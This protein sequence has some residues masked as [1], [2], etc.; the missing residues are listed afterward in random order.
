MHARSGTW[1]T[2]GWELGAVSNPFGTP[3]TLAVSERKVHA[4]PPRNSLLYKESLHQPY[5]LLAALAPSF[6]P[7]WLFDLRHGCFKISPDARGLAGQVLPAG[8]YEDH[9]AG[10]A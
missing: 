6:H 3:T 2:T 10:L 5:D 1:P 7:N 4:L 8:R 9:D